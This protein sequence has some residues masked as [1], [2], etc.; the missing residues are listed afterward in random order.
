MEKENR[1]CESAVSVLLWRHSVKDALSPFVRLV[2]LQYLS[3][4]KIFIMRLD[5]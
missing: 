2:E 4:K 1:R 5:T 3:S